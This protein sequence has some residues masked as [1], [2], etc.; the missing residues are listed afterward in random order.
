MQEQLQN[1]YRRVKIKEAERKSKHKVEQ[2]K[3]LKAKQVQ[4]ENK[5]KTEQEKKLIYEYEMEAQKLE[6]MEEELINRLQQTQLMERDA[7]KELEEAMI[8]ASM[9]KKERMAVMAKID[10]QK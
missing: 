5:L 2:H 6:Q 7:F 4:Q 8:S 9:S 3:N 10:E 1:E